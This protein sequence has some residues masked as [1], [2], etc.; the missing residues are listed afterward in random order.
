MYFSIKL[1]YF[2]PSSLHFRYIIVTKFSLSS[3]AFRFCYHIFNAFLFLEYVT[4]FWHIPSFLVYL[5]NST[6]S[7]S[8]LYLIRNETCC[9]FIYSFHFSK[10]FLG[11]RVPVANNIEPVRY[12]LI[13]KFYRNGLSSFFCFHLFYFISIAFCVLSYLH[14]QV[15]YSSA[16]FVGNIYNTI[17]QLSHLNY[18][19]ITISYTLDDDIGN[20]SV[21]VI[22]YVVYEKALRK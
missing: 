17:D 14:Y 1:F 21:C 4:Q 10:D 16:A 5:S 15:A 2:S 8:S 18:L 3:L 9:D 6:F 19:G 12:L 7:Y 13:C 11:L 22:E 20:N